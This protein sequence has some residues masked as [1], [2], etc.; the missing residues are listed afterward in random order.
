MGLVVVC[1]FYNIFQTD[2]NC[3]RF[4]EIPSEEKKMP[5]IQ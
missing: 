4:S 1:I 2:M 5:L 3:E